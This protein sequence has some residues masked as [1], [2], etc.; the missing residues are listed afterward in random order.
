MM[1]WLCDIRET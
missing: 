1:T